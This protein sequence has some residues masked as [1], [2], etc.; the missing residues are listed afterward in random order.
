VSPP[1][2]CLVQQLI[3]AAYIPNVFGPFVTFVI[4]AIHSSVNGSSPLS[5]GET[6]SSLAIISLLTSPASQFLET[7]PLVGMATSGLQRIQTFLGASPHDDQRRLSYPAFENSSS[8]MEANSAVE[9]Q[10]LGFSSAINGIQV[11]GISV[12]PSPEAP[13]ALQ[14]IGFRAPKGSLTMVIGV[15]GSGKSTL[16]RAL[17]GELIIDEG[18]IEV[19]SKS[20]AYC[21]QTP[22]LQNATVR[23]IICGPSEEANEDTEW[24][25]TVTHAC[26]FDED[27][28]QLPNR[29]DSLIGSR[30]VTLSGGQKQRLVSAALCINHFH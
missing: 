11:E 12:R 16:L 28:L 7:L 21:A 4:F 2:P 18:Y 14:N 5:Q 13:V 24:Y 3:D 29:D 26:A 19:A 22:W 27:I 15:V 6:F 30:G 25:H 20:M 23:Q 8:N 1:Q 9:L 10:N 17:A